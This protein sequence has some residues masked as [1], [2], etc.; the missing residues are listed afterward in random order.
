MKSQK[1]R[2]SLIKKSKPISILIPTDEIDNKKI[3]L[4]FMPNLIHSLDGSNIHLLISNILLFK[5]NDINLYTIHDC[6]AIDYQNIAKIELLA[7]YN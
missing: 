2:Q 7:F 5:L 6:F 4:G 1:I 3:K